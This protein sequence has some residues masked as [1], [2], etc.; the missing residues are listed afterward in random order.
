MDL[1]K[2]IKYIVDKLN[3]EGWCYIHET[4]RDRKWSNF[5]NKNIYKCL[6]GE[7][8]FDG[9]SQTNKYHNKRTR[10]FSN[11]AK[12]LL[13]KEDFID[14]VLEISGIFQLNEVAFGLQKA[15]VSFITEESKK[16]H[17]N[18]PDDHLLYNYEITEKCLDLWQCW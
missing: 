9:N 3:L 15:F 8:Y 16:K 17:E 1:E 10:Q 4:D 7:L 6:D 12:L 18:L 5:I 13:V 2:H 11:I 14:D